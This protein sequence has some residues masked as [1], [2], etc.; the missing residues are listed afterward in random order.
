WKNSL[1]GDA[2]WMFD[3]DQEVS[4]NLSSEKKAK[5]LQLFTNN[6]TADQWEALNELNHIGEVYKKNIT[7]LT[8]SVDKSH[9]QD[10]TQV[11]AVD[12]DGNK[13]GVIVIPKSNVMFTRMK[14]H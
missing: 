9:A 12:A 6:L 8:S 5:R 14:R 11:Y 4:Y 7:E 10:G 1:G 2:W 3:Y 13:V